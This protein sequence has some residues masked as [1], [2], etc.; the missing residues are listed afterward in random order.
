MLSCTGTLATTLGADQP[1]RYRG[2]VYD[3][4]TGW[5]Y[6]QSRYYSPE[7]CRFIS[8]D[9][10][11]STGQGVIGNNSYA[12]CGNNPITRT[13]AFGYSWQNN[14][15]RW[16]TPPSIPPLL[17]PRETLGVCAGL[18]TQAATDAWNWTAQAATDAWNWTAQAAT[19]A[20]NW[21][22]Q[23]ATDAWNWMNDIDNF[24]L[25]ASIAVG[26]LSLIITVVGITLT[27]TGV[28]APIGLTL[29][30]GALSVISYGITIWQS[31]RMIMQEGK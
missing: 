28:G 21:T 17:P 24:L 9:V 27:L 3:A 10:L 11:L 8:A 15:G 2:Y 29:V 6:L 31:A 20:W 12:Y 7:T 16:I 13:D 5:Y 14:T 4:E 1:F 18:L 23:A 30:S 25:V 19:D 22:A 26:T